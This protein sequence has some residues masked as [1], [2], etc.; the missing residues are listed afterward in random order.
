MTLRKLIIKTVGVSDMSKRRSPVDVLKSLHDAGFVTDDAVKKLDALPIVGPATR[1][2]VVDM[3][4]HLTLTGL[5]AWHLEQSQK[6]D[7]T[8][9]MRLFHIRAMTL[10]EGITNSVETLTKTLNGE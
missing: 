4:K 8:E 2:G 6:R 10:L 5:H 7:C 3:D 9:E 1:K